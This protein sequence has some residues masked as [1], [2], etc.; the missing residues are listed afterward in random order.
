MMRM[1]EMKIS[2]PS[3]DPEEV[4]E[5]PGHVRLSLAAA[6][7]LGFVRGWFYRNARLGCINLLQ[8]YASGC[9][10]NCAFCGLAGEEDRRSTGGSFIRVP[11]KTYPT[12]EVIAAIR[13]APAYVSRV[14]IS[15][16]THPRSPRDVLDLSRAVATRTDKAVSLLISPSVLKK[17]DLQSMRDAGAERI[18]VAIDCATEELFI[19]H[20]GKPVHGPHNWSRYWQTYEQSLTVFGEG[21]AGVHL[22]CGLGETER[23]MVQ[24]VSRARTMGGS[25][26]LFSFFPEPGSAMQSVSP[27]HIGSYRR[28]QLARWLID[29][30]KARPGD[31]EFD[32]L[33][34]IVGFGMPVDEWRRVVATG[35]PFQTS[36]CPGP[37]GKVACN[38][39]YGNEKPGRDIRN[40][41]FPPDEEDLEKIGIELEQYEDVVR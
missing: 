2:V 5:S 28:I 37:D 26:H 15:M 17:S 10:A 9:K 22:I 24:A 18:G 40:F 35:D 39:P 38:R 36:G 16:V 11:W 14:C 8:T 34:R 19:K 23:E 3:D 6:M 13:S 29:H 41:P 33:G 31:M 30:D 1:R 25:T 32:S 12:D 20:R 4:V 27:P 21:M 7:T